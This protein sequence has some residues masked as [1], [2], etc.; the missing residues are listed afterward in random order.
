M[1]IKLD[2][3]KLK[4]LRNYVDGD[5]DV[6][7]SRLEN[8]VQYKY[9]SSDEKIPSAVDD[10]WSEDDIAFSRN[11]HNRA[12]H[13]FDI[14]GATVRPGFGSGGLQ[15]E[16]M[17]NDPTRQGEVDVTNPDTVPLRQYRK[18]SRDPILSLGKR[19]IKGWCGGLRYNIN[20]SDP[21]IKTVTNYCLKKVWKTLSKELLDAAIVNGF[22]FAEK[23]VQR[24]DVILDDIDEDG[25][26][27]EVYSGKIVSIRKIKVLDPEQNFT[28]FVDE[29]DEISRVEQSQ[30][31]NE[32]SVDKD[33]IVWFALDK[34]YSNIFGVSRFK[35]A[36]EPW[37]YSKIALQQMLKHL[38]RLGSPHLEI[39]YPKGVSRQADGETRN[40]QDVA[41][42]IAEMMQ[43]M[44]VVMYP[45]ETDDK[46]NKRWSFEYAD[47]DAKGIDQYL[48]VL[49]EM[50]RRMFFAIGIPH[51]IGKDQNYSNI[52]ALV[53][54]LVVMLEDIVGQLEEVIERDVVKQ[55]VE[56]NFGP[57]YKSKVEFKI[58]RSSLNQKKLW[59]D[60]LKESLR[61]GFSE[62]GH[63]PASIPDNAKLME[64]LG[65]PYS[66][67][68]QVL[69]ESGESPEGESPADEKQRDEDSNGRDRQ[70]ERE[71]DD[72]RPAEEN[73]TDD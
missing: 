10:G 23:T 13:M 52:D 34:E 51:L 54:I 46:G 9:Y 70:T 11:A 1:E 50:E 14:R 44:G 42:D 57:E 45:S 66:S 53:D 72:E 36:Y 59:K 61:L 69:F 43:T 49:Q 39:E 60:V 16:K 21:L 25:E 4:R 8:E 64:G 48:E 33:K 27:T 65:I 68:N 38:E 40:N 7:L 6:D 62:Q 55:I 58:D 2:S 30:R 67:Y 56:Y 3:R 32:V 31:G 41:L 71:S 26:P 63:S 28:Y 12:K 17:K 18:M 73:V 35:P 19:L 5:K 37:Y 29:Y 15:N 24:E 47:T 22:G 20:S